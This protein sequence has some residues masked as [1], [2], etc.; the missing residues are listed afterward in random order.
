LA[1]LLAKHVGGAESLTLEPPSSV[2][3]TQGKNR[4]IILGL[5]RRNLEGPLH[6]SLSGLPDGVTAPPEVTSEPGADNVAIKLSVQR[7]AKVGSAVVTARAAT[8]RGPSWQQAFEVAVEA[9]QTLP[10]G[11]T[12]AEGSATV[13]DGGRTYHRFIERKLRDGTRVTFVFIPRV[14]PG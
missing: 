7:N 3:L 11:F 8:D 2:V 13:M 5:K 9:E 14:Q 1:Y 10:D 4:T 6:V 12:P